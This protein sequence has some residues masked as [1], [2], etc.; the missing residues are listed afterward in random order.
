MRLCFCAQI[1]ANMR[2]GRSGN[3]IQIKCTQ[4]LQAMGSDHIV[5]HCLSKA[6]LALKEENA[7]TGLLLSLQNCCVKFCRQHK[8]K[9][10]L[11][12][13]SRFLPLSCISATFCS[14]TTH[15]HHQRGL[16][17]HQIPPWPLP[18]LPCSHPGHQ[19]L[20]RS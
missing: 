13:I 5:A 7:C 18:R 8:I 6:C 12:Q 20:Q 16:Q 2:F 19:C 9:R 3:P 4:S 17:V 10:T 11:M 1:K 14:F 15:Q